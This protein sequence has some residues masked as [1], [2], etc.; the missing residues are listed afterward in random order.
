MV[1][2]D[3]NDPSKCYNCEKFGHLARDFQNCYN[4]GKPRNFARDCPELGKSIRKQSNA[5]VY[6]LTHGE[7]ETGTS[8]VVAG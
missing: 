5:R 7:A 8:K 6:A 2:G 3:C 1:Y 4:C